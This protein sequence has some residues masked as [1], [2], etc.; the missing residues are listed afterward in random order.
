VEALE[1][2]SVRDY[3]GRRGDRELAGVWQMLLTAFAGERGYLGAHARKAYGYSQ[4]AFKVGRPSTSGGITGAFTA[5][6]WRQ[7]VAHLERAREERF[8]NRPAQPLRARLAGRRPASSGRDAAQL[9]TLDIAGKGLVFRPGDRCLVYPEHPAVVVTRTLC[10]LRARGDEPIPLTVA[11]QHAVELRTGARPCE[12]KLNE[13]LRWAQLRP[14]ARSAAT[15]LQRFSGSGELL[16]IVDTCEYD[17]RELWD[18]IEI[19][20]A[21]GYDTRRLWQAEIWREEC[22]TRIVEPERPRMCSIASSQSRT[23]L[24]AQIALTVGATRFESNG[25]GGKGT[26]GGTCSAYLVADAPTGSEVTIDLAPARDFLLPGDPTQPIVMFAGGTGVSPFRAFVQHCAGQRRA[27]A[28]TLFAAARS[29]SELP[30]NDELQS[31]A[32]AGQLE[33]HTAFSRASMDGAPSRRIDQAMLQRS[34]AAALAD[35]IRPR[36]QGGHGA[37]VYI[38]GRGGFATTVLE[39]L[40]IVVGGNEPEGQR[41]TIRGLVGARR[42]MT[43]VFTS[44]RTAPDRTASRT[45][46]ASELVLHN[47]GEHGWWTAINGLVYDLSE[48]RELHP[49]GFRIIDDNAGIESTE[50][51]RTIRHHEDPEIEA[52]L[53]LYRIGRLRR[54]DLDNA[55]GVALEDGVPHYVSLGTRYKNGYSTSTSWSRSRTRC[56]TTSTSSTANSPHQNA[57]KT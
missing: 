20:S 28:M 14:L 21:A 55:W 47:D 22:L 9:V 17:R 26:R 54:L 2:V 25:P 18:A 7:T 53:E 40:A 43:D 30:H 39:T 8:R 35:L 24:T 38:C 49:G 57:V 37:C 10:A 3:V 15:H 51:Y 11:W 12:M 33:L 42:V 45:I 16:R 4:V 27:G 13:L 5:R 31:L 29:P 41:Q 32:Q 1:E 50:E 46:D 34:N 56:A 19:A 23:G 36:E 6:S 44:T 52:M 48:F